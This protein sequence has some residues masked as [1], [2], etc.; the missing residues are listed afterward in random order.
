MYLLNLLFAVFRC[1]SASEMHM[2]DHLSAHCADDGKN[3]DCSVGP[4]SGADLGRLN[5][6]Q[7]L[8]G[9][10]ATLTAIVVAIPAS[11]AAP[12][13]AVNSIIPGVIEH[14][15]LPGKLLLRHLGDRADPPII[16]FE[17]GA[18]YWRAGQRV[19]LSSYVVGDEVVV[20]GWDAG[21]RFLAGYM[22]TM[23]HEIDGEVLSR[24]AG[25]IRT[26]EGVIDLVPTT[27]PWVGTT[28]IAKPLESLAAGDYIVA[29]CRREPRTGEL[30]AAE[31]GVQKGA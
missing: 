10:G 9:T 2:G 23:Y 14:I 27:R 19:S 16:E 11:E 21:D 30:L 13:K 6:R 22:S 8:V 17:S 4:R 1:V 25:E 31:I 28:I 12:D 3:V 24:D 7:F 26:N 29:L 18:D 5:R 20:E 15:E